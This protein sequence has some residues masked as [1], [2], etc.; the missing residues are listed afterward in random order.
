MGAGN[1]NV[2]YNVA[3]N[4]SNDAAHRDADDRRPDCAP[5]TQAGACAYTVAPTTQNA[6]AAGGSQSVA[7]T[8]DE[9]LQLDRRE[10]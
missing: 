10:R 3:A 5:V 8:T 6:L 4:T 9:R 2:S 1:G 7:V